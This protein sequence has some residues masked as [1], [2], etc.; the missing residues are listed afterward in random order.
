MPPS[1]RWYELS[2]EADQD[3]S[4]I[5]D[6]TV[7]EFGIDQAVSYVSQFD[8]LF[9][10]LVDNSELGRKRLEIRAELRSITQESHVV[11]YRI[12]KD[13]IR[14]V[15]VLHGSRDLPKLF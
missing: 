2:P 10:Q 6:Y 9:E 3:I 15:R 13:R 4:E 1:R 5:F 14:I 7:D 11:F 12:L 8:V